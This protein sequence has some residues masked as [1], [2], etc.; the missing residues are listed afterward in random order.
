MF[1]QEYGSSAKKLYYLLGE[2]YNY[3]FDSFLPKATKKDWKILRSLIDELGPEESE[4]LVCFSVA[5]WKTIS[6]ALKIRGIPVPAVLW[7][8]RFSILDLKRELDDK[9][10]R[11]PTGRKR[12]AMY[13]D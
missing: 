1:G 13:D 4:E 6:D 8:F 5:N 12:F 11:L 9:K 7:G 3:Y 10:F 2:E